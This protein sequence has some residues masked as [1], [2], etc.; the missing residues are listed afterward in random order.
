LKAG[1]YVTY[2]PGGDTREKG[3]LTVAATTKSTTTTT[4][5]G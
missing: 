3:Q 1:E 5:A 4:A 2:C